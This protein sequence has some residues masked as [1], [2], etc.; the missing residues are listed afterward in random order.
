[1][2]NGRTCVVSTLSL[3]KIQSLGRFSFFLFILY[4]S[5]N[6][7][8]ESNSFCIVYVALL[9]SATEALRFAINTE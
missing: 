2:L 4:H 7:I 9:A 1:V 5:S 3:L 6:P 8:I